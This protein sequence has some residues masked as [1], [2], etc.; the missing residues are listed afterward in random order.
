VGKL[1]VAVACFLLTHSVYMQWGIFYSPSTT[2]MSASA[3]NE[4][5][6][7]IQLHDLN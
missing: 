5:R 2:V 1:I 3:I 7:K 6:K 4:T